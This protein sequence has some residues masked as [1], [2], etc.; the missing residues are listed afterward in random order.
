M[1]IVHVI[2]GLN[3][4]GAELMLFRLINQSTSL[5]SSN[6]HVV[7]SLNN[8]GSL[9]PEFV[10]IGVEVIALRMSFG[11]SFF[12][13]LFHLAVKIKREKPDIVQTWMYHSDLI[14]GLFARIFSSSK[15]VWGVRSTSIPQGP[16]SLSFWLVRLC[17]IFSYIIPHAIICCA[18]S[19]KDH[20]LKLG[21]AKAK[22]IVI[23]NGY[24]VNS[25][26]PDS[27]EILSMRKSFGITSDILIIGAVGR[28]DPLKGYDIFI[29]AANFLEK[30]F[31]RKILFLMIGRQITNE[32]PLLKKLIS[33]KGGKAKFMMIGE[34]NDVSRLMSMLDIFCLSSRSE[35][36]PNVVAEAMLMQVPCVVTDVGDARKIVGKNGIVVK[37][38]DPQELAS[39][40]LQLLN[41]HRDERKALGI[42]GRA[43]IIKSYSIDA[44]AKQYAKIYRDLN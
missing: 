9:G 36:F 34:R 22:M 1:K 3:K 44:V 28:F 5:D 16:F 26:L 15:V 7:I 18:N 39:G 25:A 24:L 23:P 40:I 4:G 11:V 10:K 42:S 37:R 32:N 30:S 41:M 33:E 8:F 29:E 20:H 13:G 31:E 38:N 43:E 21:F 19:S 2:S 6:K 14:G 12:S 35:G 27:Q 17:S